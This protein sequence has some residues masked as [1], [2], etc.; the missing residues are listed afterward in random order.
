MEKKLREIHIYG[1]SNFN[2]HIKLTVSSKTDDLRELI[3]E[4]LFKMSQYNTRDEQFRIEHIDSITQLK[5][6]EIE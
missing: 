4:A 2:T 6:P 1:V 5:M 3:A